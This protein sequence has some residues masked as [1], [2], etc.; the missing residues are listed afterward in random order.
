MPKRKGN[1]GVSSSRLVPSDETVGNQSSAIHV[2]RTYT[3]QSVTNGMAENVALLTNLSSCTILWVRLATSSSARRPYVHPL[4]S[5]TTNALGFRGKTCSI[6]AV[7]KRCIADG[8]AYV[9]LRP[10][11]LRFS[12]GD[13]LTA[14]S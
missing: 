10:G 8:M 2:V 11:Q 5:Q 12:A 13:H 7:N 1:F 3:D 4:G 6:N 9:S 14:R